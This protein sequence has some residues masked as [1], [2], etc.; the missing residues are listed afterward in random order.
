MPGNFRKVLNFDVF[1][2]SFVAHINFEEYVCIGKLGS[3]VVSKAFPCYTQ[4]K[5]QIIFSYLN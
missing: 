1:D 2:E 3:N 4:D 5:P